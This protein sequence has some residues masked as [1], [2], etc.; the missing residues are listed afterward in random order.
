MK[1][2]M[3]FHANLNYAYLEPDKYEFVIRHSYEMLFDTMEKYFPDTRFVFE[4]S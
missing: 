2:V 4:A 1:Y 3:I